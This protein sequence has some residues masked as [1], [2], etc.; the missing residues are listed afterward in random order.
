MR[1]GRASKVL[2]G[3][4]V[5][6]EQVEAGPAIAADAVALVRLTASTS[7]HCEP[8]SSAKSAAPPAATPTT[9]IFF[10]A[11]S[12]ARARLH[13]PAVQKSPLTGSWGVVHARLAHVFTASDIFCVWRDARGVDPPWYPHIQISRIDPDSIQAISI[14]CLCASRLPSIHPRVVP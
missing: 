2:H 13:L 4:G 8:S 5:R 3:G 9:H 14:M 11:S 6:P 12:A 10:D 7:K 1:L